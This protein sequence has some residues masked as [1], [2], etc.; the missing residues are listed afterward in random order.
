MPTMWHCP[1]LAAA[2]LC[3]SNR[4]ISPVWPTGPT[5]ANLQKESAV[6][7]WDRRTDKRALYHF[8]DPGPH[9]IWAVPTNFCKWFN[10]QFLLHVIGAWRMYSTVLCLCCWYEETFA[11][12]LSHM[13]FV[14]DLFSVQDCKR[15]PSLAVVFLYLFCVMV[16]L[17]Y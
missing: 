11:E 14:F 12:D 1:Y 15:Q 17:C 9:S 4:S 7:E 3:C 6:G 5:A 16:S 10:H 13:A 8:I 2:C